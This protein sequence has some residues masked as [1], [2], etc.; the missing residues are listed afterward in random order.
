MEKTSNCLK[1]SGSCLQ[2]PNWIQ[3]CIFTKSCVI[4]VNGGSS[5]SFVVLVDG[6]RFNF[7]LV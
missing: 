7:F 2:W 3:A 6:A 5:T 1:T 4:M